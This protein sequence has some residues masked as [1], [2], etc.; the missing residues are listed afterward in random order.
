[1]K[2]GGKKNACFV[3]H[4]KAVISAAPFYAGLDEWKEFKV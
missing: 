2:S 3:I 1:V 4:R